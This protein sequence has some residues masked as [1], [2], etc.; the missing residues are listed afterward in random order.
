MT[1]LR[2]HNKRAKRPSYEAY[3]RKR[4]AAA[5]TLAFFK[6][7]SMGIGCLADKFAKL[8]STAQQA[9]DSLRAF[10]LYD[11]EKLELRVLAHGELDT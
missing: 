4:R 11:F 8:G 1:R 9:A 2:T 6:N 10:A 7:Y 3:K 5:K